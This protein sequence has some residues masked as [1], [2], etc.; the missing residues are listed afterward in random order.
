MARRPGL[1]NPTHPNNPYLYKQSPLNK[2]NSEKVTYMGTQ[3]N[4]KVSYLVTQD[5]LKVSYLVT[6]DNHKVKYMGT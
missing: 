2:Y 6:E 1:A 3:D 5:S 4:L